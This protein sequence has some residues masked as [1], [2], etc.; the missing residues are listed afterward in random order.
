MNVLLS[1]RGQFHLHYVMVDKMPRVVMNLMSRMIVIY[2]AK[3]E[4]DPVI[5]YQAISDLFDPLP[6]GSTEIPFYK[7][8]LREDGSIGV[9]K[10]ENENTVQ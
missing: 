8:E 9:R 10:L 1:K 6:E 5:L 4:N 7:I 2:A 3:D